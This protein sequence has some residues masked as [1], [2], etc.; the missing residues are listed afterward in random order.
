[1]HLG[2]WLHTLMCGRQVGVDEFGNKYY[3][4]K[5]RLHGRERRWVVYGGKVESS[6]VPCEWH[7]WLHHTTAEPLTEKAS[8]A[9]PWQ[10]DH[11][12]NR[13][14][15]ADAYHPSASSTVVKADY[16]AWSPDA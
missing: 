12:A 4:S 14:G 5:A 2:T 8:Q 3:V 6:K 16:I 10:K 13:T 7:A 9:H 11:V 15:S 1:M